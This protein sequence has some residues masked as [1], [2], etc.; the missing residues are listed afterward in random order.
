MTTDTF[1]GMLATTGRLTLKQLALA[2]LVLLLVL[3]TL[4][5]A[6]ALSITGVQAPAT[7]SEGGL[8]NL[9]FTTD[10]PASYR[11]LED[12]AQVS[13]TSAYQ[14]VLGYDA[15]GSH[16]FT[17][18]AASANATVNAT[19]TI[20]IADTPLA[21][22]VLEPAQSDYAQATVPVALVTSI[23]ADLCYAVTESA[24]HTLAAANA[25]SYNGS[26]TLADGVHTLALKCKRAG[27]LAEQDVALR[28][29]TTPPAISL[30]PSGTVTTSPV[31]LEATTDEIATCRYA[32]QDLP[33][34]QMTAFPGDASQTH[35]AG[36]SPSAGIHTFHVRCRDAYGNEA[37]GATT[38]TYRPA[39]TAAV[40]V[41]GDNPRRAGSY[42]VTL[43]VSEPLRSV[44]TLKLVYQGGGGST[45]ALTQDSDLEYSGLLLV[46]DDAGEQVGSFSFSGTDLA[47]QEGTRITDGGLF[48]VDTV[49]PAKVT[50]F[51]AVNASG[52]VNLTWYYDGEP[53]AGFALYR[54]TT[55]GVTYM[56]YLTQVSGDSYIDEDTQT[57]VRYY[58]RIAAIDEAGNV[59]DLSSEEWASPM[60][61]VEQSRQLEQR[62]DPAFQA[63]IDDKERSLD[64][65]ILDAQRAV[66]D[67]EAESDATKSGVIAA[68]GL[69]PHA[70]KALQDLQ[71]A[72]SGYE[73]LRTRNLDR[74]AFTEQTDGIQRTVDGALAAI[75]A[76]ID[77][78][79]GADYEEV[80]DDKA[81]A[82]AVDEALRGVSPSAA[83]KAAYLASARTFQ[84][85]VTVRTTVTQ[86][87]LTSLDAAQ[88]QYTIVAK[89]LRLATPGPAIAIETVPKSVAADAS[90]L[91]A[92]RPEPVV[93]EKD[94]VLQYSYDALSDET[95][96]YALQGLVPVP[97]VR[98]GSLVVLPKPPS[99]ASP[100]PVESAATGA[101]AFPSLGGLASGQGLLIIL[102]IVVVAGLLVYYFR[103]QSE[104][105]APPAYAASPAATVPAAFPSPS[106]FRD[107]SLPLAARASPATGVATV[108]VARQEEPLA[109]L[110]LRGHTLIDASRYLD[111]LHF[112]KA[113]LA[114]YGREP[115][116]STNVREAV[117]QEL[118]LLHAKLRLARAI[119]QGHDAAYA[120]DA[121]LL[122]AAME[123]MRVKAASVGDNGSALVEK[124]KA[125]YQWLWRQ[126]NRL[127]AEREGD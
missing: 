65:R 95:V 112:Y 52:G 37:A 32:E 3:F 42:K 80:A 70:K 56:D 81:I 53:A 18:E 63:V 110:L 120:D 101:A 40:E 84:D 39:P 100:Q 31:S 82:A 19:R 60:E 109:G 86:A 55:P 125:E 13:A 72:R 79:T 38:F 124:A 78:P 113:A 9:S 58:Y 45:L 83:D 114:R 30:S 2:L 10:Q 7:I 68:L 99:P 36:L 20:E 59:G 16:V 96:Q 57:A 35:T 5:S 94:P 1:A 71:G 111:A 64:S 15:A 121:P 46:P 6:F 102:G 25:T 62:L 123:E 75:T 12:G 77:V 115:F 22:T 61:V 98:G 76:R 34:A 14:T 118:A 41:E 27:E 50:S 89:R 47:G 69:I 108:L 43:R 73:A 85:N 92:L 49:K 51:K 67:L 26:V 21:I 105:D 104:P 17:F 4:K 28:V 8:L 11:I 33:Y 119:G 66:K 23:P 97:D 117:R 44:P 126:L 24:T 87:V 122:E 116:P 90:A 106:S 88:R 103:I 54:S 107:A 93:L 74:Q 91:S 48:V 127:G 29:D